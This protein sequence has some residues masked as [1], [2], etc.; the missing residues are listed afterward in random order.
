M[1]PKEKAN[2]LF[3]KYYNRIEHTISEEYSQEEKFVVKQCVLI[4][5]DEIIKAHIHN[6]GVRH[7]KWWGEVKQEIEK[8]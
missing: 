7:L 6:E 3:G 4:A 2:E 8:L 1:T 5:V